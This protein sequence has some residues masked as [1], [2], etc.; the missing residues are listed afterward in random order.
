MPASPAQRLHSVI[1]PVHSFIYFAPEPIEAFAALGHTTHRGYFPGRAAALGPVGADVVTAVFFNFC[2]TRVA[3]GM[4]ESW[5]RADTDAVQAARM[6]A[7]GA[8]LHR[9]A[10]AAIT[11]AELAEAIDLCERVADSVGYEAKPL[12]AGNRSVPLPDDPLTRLWQ[13]TTVLREWR[14]DA[15]VAVLAATPVTA[16]EA[17]VLHGATGAFPVAVLK[18]TRAWPE[19]TWAAA[20]AGLAAR[21]LV[22]DDGSFTDAGTAFRDGIEERTDAASMPLA[23]ALGPERLDRLI[24]LLRPVRDALIAAGAFNALAR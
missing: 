2:P 17:L 22:H 6:A 23:D 1:H 12:A 18:A 5:T 14:G 16:V 13:L 19:E 7:A 20:T 15:H 21:G 9:D 11:E 3:E 10:A 4:P 8:V 24:E